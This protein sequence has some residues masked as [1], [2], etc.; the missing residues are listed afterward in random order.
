MPDTEPT[1]RFLERRRAER[2]RQ[3]FVNE[4]LPV[5]ERFEAA[6]GCL[7][8][9]ARAGAGNVSEV[10]E[11]TDWIDEMVVESGMMEQIF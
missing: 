7:Y 9:W 3:L 6:L 4:D 10:D 1:N 8:A 11:V 5:P 2:S